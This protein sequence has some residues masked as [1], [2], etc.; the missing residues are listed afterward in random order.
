MIIIK[1]PHG[2]MRINP[3]VMIQKMTL[4]DFRKWARFFARYGEDED[5]ALF[6]ERLKQAKMDLDFL[7][8]STRAWKRVVTMWAEL[9]KALEKEGRL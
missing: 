3:D 1:H 7:G 9:D 8:T 5:I 6:K 4:E 2:R